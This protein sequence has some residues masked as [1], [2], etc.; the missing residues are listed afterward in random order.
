M[1]LVFVLISSRVVSRDSGSYKQSGSS[2]NG[3]KGCVAK[4]IVYRKH[5]RP[6]VPRSTLAENR[7]QAFLSIKERRNENP[8]AA[9]Q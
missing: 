6:P 3:A 8:P 5:N 2:I 1:G 4:K 7:P 9:R